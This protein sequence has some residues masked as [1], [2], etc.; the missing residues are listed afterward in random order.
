MAGSH[1]MELADN[2]SGLDRSS[3]P[4]MLH[5]PWGNPAG[6]DRLANAGAR[7]IDRSCTANMTSTGL[8]SR[9]R[10]AETPVSAQTGRAP[11]R[12]DPRSGHLPVR[13]R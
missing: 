10:A 8:G 5:V 4:T 9:G 3:P 6:A 12:I 1:A 2:G 11:V 13:R 7:R